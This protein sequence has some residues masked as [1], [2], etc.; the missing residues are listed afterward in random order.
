M[1]KRIIDFLIHAK[2]VTYAGKGVETKSSRPNSHDLNYQDGVLRY[3]DTYLGGHQFAGEEALWDNNTP[4]WAMNYCG[5]VLSDE[6]EG[7]FL[8][9]ALLNVPEDMPFRGPLKFKN[10]NFEYRCAVNGDFEWFNGIEEIFKD[11]KKVYDCLFHG[12]LIV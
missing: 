5:R 2:K 10:G 11:G 8:K 3:I 7:N 1:D 12:G 6:F 9:E 4:F